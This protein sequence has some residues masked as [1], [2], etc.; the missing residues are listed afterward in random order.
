MDVKPKSQEI[1]RDT[2]YTCMFSKD[3]LH[4]VVWQCDNINHPGIK[5]KNWD[6]EYNIRYQ[7][8][9]ASCDEQDDTL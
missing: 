6:I 5:L 3:L 1:L 9:N 2:K 7:Q 8:N 4:C